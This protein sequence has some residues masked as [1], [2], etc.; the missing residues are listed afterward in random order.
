MSL[1]D[2]IDNNLTDK[3]TYHSYLETYQRLFNNKKYDYLNILEIGIGDP[4]SSKQN[5]GSIKMW[6]DYFI[7]SKIYG[8]DIYDITKI[9][10]QIINK[11]RINLYTSINAYDVNFI[12][13][14]FIQKNIKFDILI[15]DGPHTY[16]SMVFFIKNY[17]YLLNADGLMII[18]DIPNIEWTNTFINLVKGDNTIKNIEVVDLRYKKNRWDDI[19]LVIY[20]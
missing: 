9:N 15:D 12:N 11:D 16:E 13:K 5:G 3:N 14:E 2:L 4:K 1:Y 10:E 6:H 19:M 17:L 18:E 7:N 8:L 20:K